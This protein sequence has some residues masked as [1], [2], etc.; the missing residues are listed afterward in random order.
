MD[1]ALLGRVGGVVGAESCSSSLGARGTQGCWGESD[2][3]C[4]VKAKLGF[5]DGCVDWVT[6]VWVL[7]AMAWARPRVISHVLLFRRIQS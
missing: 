4:S 3:V 7:L 1:C 2:C 5:G 6:S